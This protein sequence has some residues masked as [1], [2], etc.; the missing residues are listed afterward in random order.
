LHEVKLLF[1]EFDEDKNGTLDLDEIF[2]MFKAND[3]HVDICK[4]VRIYSMIPTRQQ[5]AF[6][7]EEFKEL[8][9]NKT[10]NQKFKKFLDELRDAELVKP[11]GKRQFIPYNMNDLLKQLVFKTK[12]SQLTEN[13]RSSNHRKV[14]EDIESYKSLF[15][16]KQRLNNSARSCSR[17]KQRRDFSEER[18]HK[19]IR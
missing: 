14:E 8:A 9:F 19:T 15:T 4:L 17:T 12:Q 5:N 1:D 2:T 10:A 7:L 6:T 3:I 11:P 16:I 13:I 18:G